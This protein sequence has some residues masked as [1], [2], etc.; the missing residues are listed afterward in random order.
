MIGKWRG[1][2]FAGVAVVVLGGMVTYD[3]VPV[4]AAEAKY[5]LVES[6]AQFPPGVTKWEE[7]TG[8]DVDAHD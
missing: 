7:A 2:L 8:V 5:Q 1:F 3:A 6:W 4:R